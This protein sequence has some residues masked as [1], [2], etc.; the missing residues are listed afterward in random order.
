MTDGY[1]GKTNKDNKENPMNTIFNNGA[2]NHMPASGQSVSSAGTLPPTC[3]DRPGAVP[4]QHP[5]VYAAEV[6]IRANPE[7]SRKAHDWLLATVREAPIHGS[8]LQ[9]VREF[10]VP[11]PATAW[12]S[13]FEEFFVLPLGN[14]LVH[15]PAVGLRS[16][17]DSPRYMEKLRMKLPEASKGAATTARQV[18]PASSENAEP[19]DQVAPVVIDGS[20]YIQDASFGARGLETIIA[21]LKEKGRTAL[22]IFDAATRYKARDA[23][24]A[25]SV[26]LINRLTKCGEGEIAPGGSRADEYLLLLA[27]RLGIDIVSND[28]Y[29]AE[30]YTSKYPWLSSRDETPRRVHPAAIMLGRVLIPSLDIC[31]QLS[32]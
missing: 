27:D 18:Q 4:S 13:K 26:E 25:A 30:E 24:D 8:L 22:A 1:D 23:G 14:E 21:A 15:H 32:A 20:N 19:T 17:L 28:R 5:A 12:V 3:A 16:L 9:Y 29:R 31:R 6:W 2:N 11:K 10:G 7:A